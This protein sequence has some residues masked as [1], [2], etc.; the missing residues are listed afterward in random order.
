MRSTRTTLWL[1]VALAALTVA[2]FFPVWRF[3]FVSLDDPWY[4]TA[5]AEVLKGLTWHGVLWA[6]T[7]GSEFYWHPLTWLSHMLD[8]QLYGLNAGGHHVTNLILHVTATLLLFAALRRMTGAVGRSAFVAAA[9]AIHPLHVEP[10]A[11]VAERKE[12][13]S[14]VCWMLT[15]LAY[16]RY[17]RDPRWPR[18]AA[19][20]A[21]FLL[22]LMAKPM[23]VTL[24]AVLLLLDA[25][26]LGRLPLSGDIRG[27]LRGTWP[28][29]REKLPL[30]ALALASGVVTFFNQYAAG[31][32]RELGNY[33]FSFRLANAAVSYVTYIL[34]MFWPADLA[35]FYPYPRSL[36]GWTVVGCAVALLAVSVLVLRAWRRPYLI[37]GWFWFTVTLLPV[38]GLIQVGDQAMADRFVYVPLIGLFIVVAWGVPELQEKLERR[39][40]P[41]AAAG[42]QQTGWMT[43]GAAVVVIAAC[44]AMSAVQLQYWKDSLA[45]WERAAAVTRDNHRAHANLAELME[46]QGN[47][48]RAIA[49]YTEGIRIVPG[50]TDLRKRLSL[51]LIRR[52]RLPEAAD[53]LLNVVRLD[54]ADADARNNLGVILEQQGRPDDALAQYSEA[55]RLRPADA[56]AHA[57]VADVLGGMGRFTEAAAEYRESLRIEPR[58][59]NRRYNLAIT[60]F[61]LGETREAMQQLSAV[62]EI[63]P[64]FEPARRA[65]Q[66]MTR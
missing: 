31:A 48:D 59:P 24:P 52:D 55:L 21:A 7:T 12:V 8:V 44:A 16:E 29:L 23:I 61:R 28:L 14:A 62:L 2:V 39:R 6:F 11:W 38:I 15:L 41:D 10:V 43:A 3:D 46:R 51:L 30:F 13:L 34:R 9:F 57:N 40:R 25:W 50:A 35:G 22:G 5:N 47:I 19:V 49:E 27:R 33:A 36:S 63:D 37:V 1:S 54:P 4:V 26:P 45:L 65:L 20:V 66:Q 64:S 18:Y 56:R 58:H 17:A 42:Q 32:V 60:L 53:Q